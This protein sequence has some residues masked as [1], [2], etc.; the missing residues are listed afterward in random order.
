VLDQVVCCLLSL[1]A[2][3]LLLLLIVSSPR[4]PRVVLLIFSRT[5]ALNKHL[6]YILV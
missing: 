4:S 2:S 1:S 3:L 6:H 5:H